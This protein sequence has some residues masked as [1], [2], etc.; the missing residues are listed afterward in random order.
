MSWQ[1]VPKRLNELIN[2][3]DKERARRAMEA[4]LNMGKIEVDVLERAVEA[5]AA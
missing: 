2:D 1:I 4:M 3:P 5:E